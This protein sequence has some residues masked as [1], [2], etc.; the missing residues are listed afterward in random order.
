MDRIKQVGRWI[1][2]LLLMVPIAAGTM[3]VLGVA[4]TLMP[5]FV[6]PVLAYDIVHGIE[7]QEEEQCCECSCHTD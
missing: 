7:Y 5:F 4:A 6:G 2:V 1:L 3:L